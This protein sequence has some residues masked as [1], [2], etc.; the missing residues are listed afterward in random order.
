MIVAGFSKVFI[1]EIVEI[2]KCV[3]SG[4]LIPISSGCEKGMGREGE[5]RLLG[6]GCSLASHRQYT[7]STTPP[8]GSLP[9][10]LQAVLP[11]VWAPG[12]GSSCNVLLAQRCPLDHIPATQ[13]L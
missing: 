1:G 9:S 11:A 2:G 4:L 12:A 7:P 13:I 5:T 6:R 3:R 10:I 8:Q